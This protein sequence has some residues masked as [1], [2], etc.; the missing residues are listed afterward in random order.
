MFLPGARCGLDPK[1]GL[2]GLQGDDATPSMFSDQRNY[3]HIGTKKAIS[4][5]GNEKNTV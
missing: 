1:A 3:T 4:K 5:L 2:H